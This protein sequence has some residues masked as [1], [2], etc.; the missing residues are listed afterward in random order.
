MSRIWGL[1][2]LPWLG[3]VGA[4]IAAAGGCGGAGTGAPGTGGT[5]GVAAATQSIS[6]AVSGTPFVHAA[7][8]LW[9]GMPDPNTPAVTVVYLF[10]SPVAC[11]AITRAGWDA[12]LGTSNQDLEM[13]AA[14]TTPGTYTV[15][16][17][18]PAALAA[19]EAVVNHSV[20]TTSPVEQIA[21]AGST[22][23][24]TALNAGKDATG[25]FQI[26]F[27]NGSLQGAFDATWCANGR[28]P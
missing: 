26:V 24:L 8:A 14:G 3:V 21:S 17:G 28:E 13:K 11:S 18:N 25:S 1:T 9:I 22:V 5:G 4:C 16:G 15:I 2:P 12:A 20:L 27:P 19:G 23:T 6:G 7:T 10:E